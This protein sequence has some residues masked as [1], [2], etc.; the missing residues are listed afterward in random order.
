MNM[1]IATLLALAGSHHHIQTTTAPGDRAA[2]LLANPDKLH[3]FETTIA[4]TGGVLLV[5]MLAGFLVGLAI[6]RGGR[7]RPEVGATAVALPVGPLGGIAGLVVGHPVVGLAASGFALVGAFAI[8]FR[9]DQADRRAGKD[10]RRRAERRLSFL[11]VL[12]AARTSRVIETAKPTFDEVIVGRTP[13]R[14]VKLVRGWASGRHT[15]V[16]GAPGSGKSTTI[17]ALLEQHVRGTDGLHHGAVVV[18]PKGDATIAQAA[19]AAAAAA[20]V[21]FIEFTPQGGVV[22]DM[23]AGGDVDRRTDKILAAEEW[24]EPHYLAGATTYLREAMRTLEA[25]ETHPTLTKVLE[26][27]DPDKHEN[28]AAKAGPQYAKQL[29]DYIKALTPRQRGDLAGLRD[30]IA[31]LGRS[32]MAAWLDPDRNPDAERLDLTDA[33]RYGAVVLFTLQADDYPMLSKK[34]AAAIVLDLIAIAQRYQN[35]PA[36]TF[37]ALDEFGAI[38]SDLVL[39]LL[40]RAR[41][42]GFSVTLAAQTLADFTAASPDGSMASRVIGN[43][44]A[45]VV[46]RLNDAEEAEWVAQVAGTKDSWTTTQR[47]NLILPANDG[48]RTL[49]RDFIVHPDQIKTLR[50]GEAAVIGLDRIPGQRRVEI[51]TVRTPR[52]A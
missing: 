17:A 15:G 1:N 51:T 23:L 7:L 4:S 38:D 27:M 36:P 26:L 46:G 2:G 19:R 25:T 39:R 52:L 37:V 3:H 14:V 35:N 45:M 50:R 44:N 5:A 20:G 9:L 12:R 21:P 34:L 8:A 33:V 31:A 47:T 22:Y 28:H 6:H 48:T 11:G 30:R 18:D 10:R 13:T 24:T 49:D 40:A 29:G 43:L 16:L 41:G 32:D 42:A